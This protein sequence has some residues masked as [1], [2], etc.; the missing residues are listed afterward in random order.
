MTTLVI[1]L[2]VDILY[3]EVSIPGFVYI[4][5][6]VGWAIAYSIDILDVATALYRMHQFH[7][8]L[9]RMRQD[10]RSE[11]RSKNQ[12][13]SAY[14]RIRRRIGHLLQRP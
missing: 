3:P 8:L 13:R 11:R 1:I 14:G 9:K 5:V 6:T 12:A 7:Q 10:V 4:G 2:L